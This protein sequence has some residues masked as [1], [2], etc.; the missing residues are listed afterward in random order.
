[1]GDDIIKSGGIRD[2]GSKAFFVEN[3]G[4]KVC[5]PDVSKYFHPVNHKLEQRFKILYRLFPITDDTIASKVGITRTTMNRYRRGV[6][7]PL[8]SL[9]IR[10]AQAISELSKYQVDSAVIWGS[11]LIFEDWK[12]NKEQKKEEQQDGENSKRI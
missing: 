5:S 9:K 6:W 1:M 8:D 7:I 3:E 2:T 11:D 10:I 12:R 4:V